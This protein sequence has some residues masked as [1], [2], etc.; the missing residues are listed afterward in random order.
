[1]TINTVHVHPS[2]PKPAFIAQDSNSQGLYWE[3]DLLNGVGALGTE[4]EQGS[5][6]IRVK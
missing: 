4:L 6:K 2:V 5:V 3:G 1:M